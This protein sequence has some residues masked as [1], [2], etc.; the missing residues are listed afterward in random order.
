[1]KI[2]DCCRPRVS[3]Q[4]RRSDTIFLSAP[5]PQAFSCAIIVHTPMRAL[6][7]GGL[8]R[9][10]LARG[11]RAD[12][13][14]AGAPT[15][16]PRPPATHSITWQLRAAA[17]RS[18]HSSVEHSAYRRASWLVVVPICA[19]SRYSMRVR[20]AKGKRARLSRRAYL[21][22]GTPKPMQ[23]AVRYCVIL[24]AGSILIKRRYGKK[25]RNKFAVL[26]GYLGGYFLCVRTERHLYIHVVLQL[27]P[28]R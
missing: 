21:S 23:I 6:R 24:S 20:Y 13:S 28:Q 25:Y 8:A 17:R 19:A 10:A 11:D 18:L 9:R 1:M 2:T 7:T 15:S 12:T 16:G 22:F 14:P 3:S 5:S 27:S 26:P 4:V